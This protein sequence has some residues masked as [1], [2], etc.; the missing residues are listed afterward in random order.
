MKFYTIAAFTLL[1]AC[2]STSNNTANTNQSGS[3]PAQ[4]ADTEQ[5]VM[6]EN[7]LV[8]EM[9]CLA[10]YSEDDFVLSSLARTHI[11]SINFKDDQQQLQVNFGYSG[12]QNGELLLLAPA[13]TTTKDLI[14]TLRVAEAGLCEMLL[15]E[16]ACFDLTKWIATDKN[17][18]LNNLKNPIRINR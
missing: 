12:C 8:K 16:N 13:D 9:P 4:K 7:D 18:Y 15:E 17:L 10:T 5:M 14:L 6:D 11:L 3:T 1:I 2:K